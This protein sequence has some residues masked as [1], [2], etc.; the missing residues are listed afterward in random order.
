MI[1]F[2]LLGLGSAHAHEGHDHGAPP[3]VVGTTLAPR[4]EAR[5]DLFEIVG[6]LRGEEMALYLDQAADN[7]PITQ[8]GIEIES[9]SFSAKAVPGSGGEFLLQAGELAK[10]GKHT[11]TIT[12]E[13]G[14]AADL[15]T[16]SF[17]L[18]AP[19]AAPARESAAGLTGYGVAAAILLIVAVLAWRLKQRKSA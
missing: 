6:V 11:L 10:P 16:A 4:F 14:D 8:A 19:T 7:A 17:D 18:A 1:L 15:L 12:I 13:A 2:M 9:G 5:S 3:P